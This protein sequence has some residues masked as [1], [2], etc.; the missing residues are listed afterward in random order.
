M[1]SP[2]DSTDN[3]DVTK[4]FKLVDVFTMLPSAGTPHISVRAVTP[5]MQF[6]NGGGGGKELG[7]AI[8]Q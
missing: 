5:S 7:L 6:I 2:A 1:T 3:D 8:F 4:R